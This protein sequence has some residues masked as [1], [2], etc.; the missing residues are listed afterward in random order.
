MRLVIAAVAI[1]AV[2]QAVGKDYVDAL[3]KGR[4]SEALQ[5]LDPLL[6]A[7]MANPRLWAAKGIAL[8]GLGRTAESLDS[9]ERALRISPKMMAA[10]EGAAETAYQLK[11]AKTPVY[12]D[13][14]LKL[15]SANQTAHAMSATLAFE[16]RNC[17]S[18][19]VHFE[20][21]R[22][23]I[24]GSE[25][26]LT[27]FGSCLLSENKALEASQL[28]Q[29]LLTENPADERARYNLGLCQVRAGQTAAAIVTLLPLA[30]KSNPKAEA[31]SLLA[32]AYAAEFKVEAAIAAL[33]RAI[34]LEPGD[35]R[36]YVDLATL[37]MDHQASQLANHI[38]NAGIGNNPHSAK[39]HAARGALLG[40]LGKIEEAE[41][42]FD[43]ASRL[44]ADEP[45]GSV[46]LSVLYRETAQAADAL[47][48]LREKLKTF[49][50]DYRL[51]Y[52]LADTLMR[53]DGGMDAREMEEARAA[54]E[55]SIR[56]NTG[57]AK[58][59]VVMGKLYVKS[60]QL[61]KAADEFRRALELD[62]VDRA[63]LQQ[64]LL[65]LRKLGRD[66]EGRDIAIKLKA[67]LE[68]DRVTE[69]RN[70]RVQLK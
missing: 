51:N 30:G 22:Q 36:N 65:V 32:A 24:A 12:L 48:L 45:Y 67:A 54:I 34:E 3:V 1:V 2:L 64:L 29:T 4:Y 26:A 52:L 17:E 58:S 23:A 25:I 16:S 5:A 41:A 47:A 21:S 13:R 37:C 19:I 68:K 18:A 60:N 53:K 55:R 46:G 66:E 15:D 63:A 9:F 27:Q 69:I 42:E 14:I 39:L 44:Q 43:A 35:E 61:A 40:E 59:H 49:P 7:D 10:L 20:K 6:S 33:R 62:P 11:S 70:N 57:F 8:R 50:S 38:L 28:F 56:N 31:L